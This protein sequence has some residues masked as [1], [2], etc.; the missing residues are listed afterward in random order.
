M[1]ESYLE[2]ENTWKR[3]NPYPEGSYLWYTWSMDIEI[4]TLTDMVVVL[5]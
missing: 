2:L 5:L 3:L 1:N 4:G